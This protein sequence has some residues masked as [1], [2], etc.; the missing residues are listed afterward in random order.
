MLFKNSNLYCS[1]TPVSLWNTA[2]RQILRDNWFIPAVRLRTRDPNTG[3]SDFSSTWFSKI[4]KNLINASSTHKGCR[5]ARGS[6]V[7][8][9]RSRGEHSSP[10]AAGEGLWLR[11][12]GQLAALDTS[13][14]ETPLH[15]ATQIEGFV[16][17]NLSAHLGKF[18]LKKEKKNH[19]VK[20]DPVHYF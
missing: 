14:A 4:R 16:F 9:C 10:A 12:R 20:A 11:A 19:Q 2:G 6:L 7:P 17:L 13:K 8:G 15:W 3:F 5:W 18:T 1:G